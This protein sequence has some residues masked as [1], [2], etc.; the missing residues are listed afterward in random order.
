L[1][2]FSVTEDGLADQLLAIIVKMERPKL[3]QRKEKVIQDQNQY[4]I[5]L[6]ELEEQILS[7]LNQEGDLLENEPMVERLENSKKVS[8]QVSVAMKQSREAEKEINESSNAYSPAAARGSR[9][10]HIRY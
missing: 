8:E 9:I 10:F 7:D 1:I 6:M 4:K 5:T 2:N 3:A